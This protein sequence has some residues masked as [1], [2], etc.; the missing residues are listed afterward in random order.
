M[1]DRLGVVTGDV[2]MSLTLD[3]LKA[4]SGVLSKLLPPSPLLLAA[5]SGSGGAL[6]L[7]CESLQPTGSFKIRGASYRIST[8]TPEERAAGVVAYSTGNHAQA[9]AKAASDQGVKS[10]I[11]MSADVPEA[12]VSATRRWGAQVIM[13]APTSKARRMLAEG[14]SAESGAVLIPPY[15]DFDV[16]AGQ[17]SIAFE[18]QRQLPDLKQVAVYVPI[19][20]GG[21]IAGVAA[22]MKAIEPTARVIGV[23][24]ELE[25]DALRSFESGAIFAADG[26]SASI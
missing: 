15:D 8:L 10:T 14:I 18:L 22:A 16:M 7:K 4:A 21:L 26:P 20:G 19:G 25:A 11:V 5:R 24:P 3:R 12:K 9:V 23:E 13:A 6:W 1:Q 17:G 2:A